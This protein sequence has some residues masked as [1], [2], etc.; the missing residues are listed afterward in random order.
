[1]FDKII[2]ITAMPDSSVEIQT[3]TETAEGVGPT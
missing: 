1:V 3:E 2:E